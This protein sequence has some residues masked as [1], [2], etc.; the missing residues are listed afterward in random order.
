MGDK[1]DIATKGKRE[2]A[3]L[4]TMQRQEITFSGP[5]PP[6]AVIEGYERIL[7]GSADR[8]LKMAEEQSKHR[9]ELEKK[10]IA[11][12]LKQSRRGQLFGFIIALAGMALCYFFVMYDMKLFAGIFACVILTS[13]VALFV[14]GKKMQLKNA[15]ESQKDTNSIDRKNKKKE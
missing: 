9:Q 13:L 15:V 2:P 4:A 10:A 12:D 5:I 11:E 3:M 8:I 1:K 6:P 7:P 14:L